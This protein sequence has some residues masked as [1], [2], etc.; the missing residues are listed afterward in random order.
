M[1]LSFHW[2]WKRCEK[3]RV[4]RGDLF[5]LFHSKWRLH[6]S[7]SNFG[8]A[9]HFQPHLARNAPALCSL[10]LLCALC[11][12]FL[13]PHFPHICSRSPFPF[14]TRPH[15][16]SRLSPHIWLRPSVDSL[17]SSSS[18]FKRYIVCSSS[19]WVPL[20]SVAAPDIETFI[21]ATLQ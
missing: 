7:V 10:H 15:F 3:R 21:M 17:T 1:L 6:V 2:V 18:F 16:S 5:E 20:P 12:C 11:V 19:F 13:P 4:H 9:D 8:I 14:L